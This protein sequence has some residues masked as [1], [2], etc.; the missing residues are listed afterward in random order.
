MNFKDA[1]SRVPR[2]QIEF[3]EPT[4]TKQC[5]QEECDINEI[6]KKYDETGVIE[7]EN[8][9]K[10]DYG[11]YLSVAGLPCFLKPNYRSRGDV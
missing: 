2:V 3:T 10:G 7:H 8:R 6:M 5:F 4:L 9:F 11:D 1:Y